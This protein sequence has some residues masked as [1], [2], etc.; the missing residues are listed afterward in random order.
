MGSIMILSKTVSCLRIS[1]RNDRRQWRRQVQH[2]IQIDAA[3]G[4]SKGVFRGIARLVK[5]P[6]A[7]TPMLELEDGSRVMDERQAAERWMR[8]ASERHDG[9]PTSATALL[10]TIMQARSVFAAMFAATIRQEWACTS[11]P[12]VVH[13]F[14]RVKH[15]RAWCEDLLLPD[16]FR[17]FQ[18]ELGQLFH[19]LYVKAPMALEEP[20]QWRGGN[21]APNHSCNAHRE[22]AVPL[23][24]RWRRAL[25]TPG[26]LDIAAETQCGGLAGR[27]TDVASH[28]L[29]QMVE[30]HRGR[31][32]ST[33][34]VFVDVIGAF[35]NVVRSLV[36]DD[37]PLLQDARHMDDESG[38]PTALTA[39]SLDERV[40]NSVTAQLVYTWFSIVG[41]DTVSKF[42]RGVVPG[43][44]E[45]DQQFTLVI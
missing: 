1:L 34:V 37:S 24:H 8:F 4:F 45:A 19:P 13:L 39:T 43:D 3:A 42:H 41:S 36:T 6:T 35:Y 40:L 12:D 5:K 23:L 18:Q 26:L 14:G 16:L 21:L 29:R 44:P 7:P 17:F 30:H 10:E 15:G 11:V 38:M 9:Q 25:V 32:R 27:A 2:Q 31:K 22:I 20:V 33:I 28:L